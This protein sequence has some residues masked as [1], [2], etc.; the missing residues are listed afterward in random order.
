MLRHNLALIDREG[1]AAYLD[2]AD[3]LVPLYMRFGFRVAGPASFRTGHD[4]MACGA[5]RSGASQDG[6]DSGRVVI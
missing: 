6:G 5:H 1:A 2:C 4:P 3:E